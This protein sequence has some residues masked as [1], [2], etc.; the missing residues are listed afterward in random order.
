MRANAYWG[1]L[2]KNFWHRFYDPRKVISAQMTFPLHQIHTALRIY[3]SQ[4][5]YFILASVVA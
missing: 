2:E 4:P 3:L 1:S 5:S